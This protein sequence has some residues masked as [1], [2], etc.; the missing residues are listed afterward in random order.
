MTSTKVC[1][2]YSD[3]ANQPP[4]RHRANHASSKGRRSNFTQR[5]RTKKNMI[6]T[7]DK[8]MQQIP[9]QMNRLICA[10]RENEAM[11]AAI[12]ERFSSLL[13][14]YVAMEVASEKSPTD[15]PKLAPLASDIADVVTTSLRT[16]HILLSILNRAEV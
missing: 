4:S 15:A 7:E 6:Q 10:V 2:V 3:R 9:E 13:N 12:A 11:A 16:Q 14:P 8:R 5:E 1:E